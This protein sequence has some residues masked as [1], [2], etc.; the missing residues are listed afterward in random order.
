[1]EGKIHWKLPDWDYLKK[2]KI[3]YTT[4]NILRMRD[5]VL[6]KINKK[7]PL[8]KRK[9]IINNGIKILENNVHIIKKYIQ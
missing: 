6:S 4:S 8:N 7:L 2:N 9:K 5:I 3:S 1:M